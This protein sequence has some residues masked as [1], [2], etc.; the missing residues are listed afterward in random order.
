[1]ADRKIVPINPRRDPKIYYDYASKNNAQIVGVIETHPHAD[2]V[3]AHLEIHK[4]LN[5][6]V[7]MSSLTNPGYPGTAFDDGQTIM[8]SES[9]GLRSMYTP[10]HAPDHISAVLFETERI[11]QSSPGI[12]Y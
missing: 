6:P 12:R 10:G 3:S 5:V 8:I 9:I 2:F 7:Y 11:S 4:S 1:M